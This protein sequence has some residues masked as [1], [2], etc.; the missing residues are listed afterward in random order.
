MIY[1]KSN[2]VGF[3]ARSRKPKK[4]KQYFLKNYL[5]FLMKIWANWEILGYPHKKN[6]KSTIFSIN[7][8]LLSFEIR[9]LDNGTALTNIHINKGPGKEC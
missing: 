8:G 2:I 4:N 6:L 5:W 3:P 7:K 9:Q 1:F